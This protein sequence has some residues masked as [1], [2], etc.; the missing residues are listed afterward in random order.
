MNINIENVI[1]KYKRGLPQEQLPFARKTKGWR[2]AHLLW[3][4]SRTFFNYSPVRNSVMHK[5]VNYDLFNGKLHMQDLEYVINPEG[6]KERATPESIQHYP[7][8]NSKL[9]VLRGEESKR[10]FDFKVV[11]TNPNAI[12]EIEENKKEAALQQLQ[13]LIESQVQDENEFNQK[14][15]KMSDYFMYEWQ[16]MRETRANELLKHYIKEYNLPLV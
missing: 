2:V 9:Q 12:S 6:I 14:L 4:D 1:S 5:K 16:D 13:A 10:V 11:V 15:D 7:V 3:A 8:L